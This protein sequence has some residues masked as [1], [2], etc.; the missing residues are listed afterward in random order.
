M[1]RIILILLL[2]TG[3]NTLASAQNQ[4]QVYG[5][6]MILKS[7]LSDYWVLTLK[8][9]ADYN[10]ENFG[11]VKY[12]KAP[13]NLKLYLDSDSILRA[14]ICSVLSEKEVQSLNQRMQ[15]G[16]KVNKSGKAWDI[17]LVSEKPGDNLLNIDKPKLEKLL[18]ELKKNL[19][20]NTSK[21]EGNYTI[22]RHLWISVEGLKNGTPLFIRE[23][24]TK[25]FE[26]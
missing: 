5:D 2:L 15:L 10:K 18:V 3:I 14:T 1:K 8:S 16:V 23:G 7:S 22:T 20:F 4:R 13:A 24:K 17:V 21:W 12:D 11:K 26:F 9:V 25:N 6:L 19:T